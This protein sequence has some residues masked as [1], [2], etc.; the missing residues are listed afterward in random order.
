MHYLI[1][2]GSKTMENFLLELI[3]M[4]P[5]LIS[6]S[7]MIIG[8]FIV[9]DFN[10]TNSD[11]TKIE[12]K[13]ENLDKELDDVKKDYISQRHLDDQI[14]NLKEKIETMESNIMAQ[15]Q[16]MLATSK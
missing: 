5:W 16:L 12:R 10:R 8:F 2:I 7:A 14:T 13:V 3:K 1:I 11:I 15:F 4:L 9:R 6:S